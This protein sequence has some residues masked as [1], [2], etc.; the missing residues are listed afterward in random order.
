MNIYFNKTTD[1]FVILDE[2]NKEIIGGFVSYDAAKA[3]ITLFK[4]GYL[5][6]D[7]SGVFS[8]LVE[9][10]E[11]TADEVE[12]ESTEEEPLPD[13]PSPLKAEKSYE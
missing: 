11:D 12:E 3:F 4:Q 7:E 2:H 5:F 1:K 6:E 8:V 10:L 13:V 9:P